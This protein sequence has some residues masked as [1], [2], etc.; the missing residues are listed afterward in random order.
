MKRSVKQ[1]KQTVLSSIISSN[2]LPCLGWGR[3][4]DPHLNSM[5]CHSVVRPDLQ[6]RSELALLCALRS[7]RQNLVQKPKTCGTLLPSGVV[8][9]DYLANQA[10]P[11]QSRRCSDTPRDLQKYHNMGIVT[12]PSFPIGFSL[13]AV[14]QYIIQWFSPHVTSSILLKTSLH[15]APSHITLGDTLHFYR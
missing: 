14:W 4:Q 2:L 12:Q 13:H 15:C 1:K 11:M 3:M 6:H 8:C 9:P 10:S 7:F 5:S